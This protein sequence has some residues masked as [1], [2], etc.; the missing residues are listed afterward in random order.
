MQLSILCAASFNNIGIIL[1]VAKDSEMFK[2]E[3]REAVNI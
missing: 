3:Q 2:D 1:E